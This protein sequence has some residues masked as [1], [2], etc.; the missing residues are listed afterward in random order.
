MCIRDRNSNKRKMEQKQSYTK[1]DI[2]HMLAE[3]KQQIREVENVL[4]KESKAEQ[5]N[6]KRI[7]DYS[8]LQK[9]LFQKKEDYERALES[10]RKV[11]EDQEVMLQLSSE[12]LT[13]DCAGKICAALFEEDH[14][15]YAARVL[16]ADEKAQTAEVLWL[17]FKEKTTLPAKYVKM[18][19]TPEPN[20]LP[21]G[22]YCE[23]IYTEDGRW[24]SCTI[25]RVV[26]DGYQIKFKKYSTQ[27]VVPIEY[28]RT[29]KDGKPIR[30]PIEEMSTFKVPEHLKVRPTDTAEQKRQKKRKVKLIKQHAKTKAADKDAKERQ[31]MWQQFNSSAAKHKKGYYALKKGESIFKSPD[32][33]EG[34][35][36]VMGLSLI[37]ICRCRRLLT[38]RSRWSPYH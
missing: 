18:Q 37:H 22:T 13:L 7:S 33:V 30:R 32:T 6:Q 31:N 2:E 15:W 9:E 29:M 28:I 25:D 26:E 3:C 10:M 36:G 8:K 5:K 35:V 1:K 20:E 38:C 17:G 21:S 4:E 24:Y 14:R 34:R 27:R 19:K 23:A 12:P 11:E 16:S